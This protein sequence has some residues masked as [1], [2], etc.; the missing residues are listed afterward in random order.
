M[1]YASPC[2]ECLWYHV[3]GHIAEGTARSLLVCLCECH[4]LAGEHDGIF[5][6]YEYREW[7]KQER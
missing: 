4:K 1:L 2:T 6:G 7:Q 3:Q 5:Y